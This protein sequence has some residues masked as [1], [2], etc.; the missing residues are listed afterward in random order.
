MKKFRDTFRPRSAETLA[1][2]ELEEAKRELLTA[3]SGQEYAKRMAE[4]HADR[5]ARLT[6]YLKGFHDEPRDI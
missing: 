5:V 2:I 4:Y 3:L 1:T 6:K